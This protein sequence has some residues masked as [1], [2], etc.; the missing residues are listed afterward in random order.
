MLTYAFT[1]PML[2]DLSKL[3]NLMVVLN[4]LRISAGRCDSLHALLSKSAY[5]IPILV[6]VMCCS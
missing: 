5:K 6:S 2:Y 3:Y 1:A 4:L